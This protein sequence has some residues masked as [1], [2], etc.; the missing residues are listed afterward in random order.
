MKNA[1]G[2]ILAILSVALLIVS[3]I[4]VVYSES[5]EIKIA[6]TNND[7]DDEEYTTPFTL[8]YSGTT[9]E[10]DKF[11]GG[12]NGDTAMTLWEIISM[13]FD[14]DIYYLPAGQFLQ[15]SVVTVSKSI[16][17]VGSTDDNGVPTTYIKKGYFGTSSNG[18]L[19]NCAFRSSELAEDRGH[20]VIMNLLIDNDK[21]N[22]YNK[23]NSGIQAIGNVS[24]DVHNTKITNFNYFSALSVNAANSVNGA[25]RSV[26]TEMHCYG[27]TTENNM[28]TV[29]LF[30]LPRHD[31]EKGK[32]VLSHAYFTYDNKHIEE[33]FKD[34]LNFVMESS[35]TKRTVG[36]G[37][38]LVNG[39]SLDE[40]TVGELKV[41]LKG[42]IYP[43]L[44]GDDE[45]SEGHVCINTIADGKRAY[46]VTEGTNVCTI[47]YDLDGGTGE[48][49]SSKWVIG[50]DALANMNSTISKNNCIFIGW[51][52][53]KGA[54]TPDYD[55]TNTWFQINGDVTLYA[56]YKD[57]GQDNLTVT[58]NVGEGGTADKDTSQV[59]YGG[60][61]EVH[62][63]AYKDCKIKTVT[64]NGEDVGAVQLYK[65]SNIKSNYTITV[66][67]ETSK[68]TETIVDEE[69]GTITEK[70]VTKK[71]LVTETV[72]KV[73]D[74]NG[75]VN[76]LTT[77]END[78][79]DV[80]TTSINGEYVISNIESK[81]T[82][83]TE[84]SKDVSTVTDEQLLVAFKQA[85]MLSETEETPV[86]IID[87]G[88]ASSETTKSTDV[89]IA[90]SDTTKTMLEEND[91]KIVS[92][93]GTVTMDGD[94]VKGVAEEDTYKII[95]SVGDPK[96][97]SPEQKEIIGENKVVSAKVLV[98]DNTGKQTE[99][100]EKF[101]GK[102]QVYLSY[103]V[104][105]PDNFKVFFVSQSGSVEE[106]KDKVYDA[107][108]EIVSFT[109]EHFSE[110]MIQEGE[111]VEESNGIGIVIIS[112]I[113]IVV[114]FS[115][116]VSIY[117]FVRRE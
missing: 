74:S 36:Y 22:L 80:T 21:S 111:P 15:S 58:V 85:K 18:H 75:D 115:A 114:A 62:F 13:A 76:V 68:G 92:A 83:S 45:L 8:V 14:K 89:S 34:V 103:K 110:Y 116:A 88:K 29:N 54:T 25:Y 105:Y 107:E 26:D 106:I 65:L 24:V 57:K 7:A 96:E 87:T 108:N 98:E 31:D 97:L 10:N 61:F 72:E 94:A 101:E 19:F 69:T 93:T 9:G 51:S 17:I 39:Y 112:A 104:E 23:A 86:V 66:E 55:A 2:R 91:L 3:A 70:T 100:K 32:D 48:V 67:F 71:S 99:Y 27:V 81:A 30:A 79:V 28:S 4:P 95:I 35:I 47:T 113:A 43:T 41:K 40:P 109:V 73:T 102:V 60:S 64:V 52:E 49:P 38:C 46:V 37:N 5:A 50:S 56:V 53:T 84:E 20:V 78:N 42:G 6:E 12:R 117:R 59:A 16:K 11:T 82:K 63:I 1:Y 33:D 90:L 77:Y 44:K